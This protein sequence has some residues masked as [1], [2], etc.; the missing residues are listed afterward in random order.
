[1]VHGE[2]SSVGGTT[3]D[4]PAEGAAC[5]ESGAG[6][7]G[8]GE[9]GYEGHWLRRSYPLPGL[10][11]LLARVL[12]PEATVDGQHRVLL[13]E[14]ASL[15]T[16]GTDGAPVTEH[17]L[18][19]M[20]VA[21]LIAAWSRQAASAHA[22]MLRWIT[23]LRGRPDMNR[24]IPAV[25][26]LDATAAELQTC[27]GISRRKARGLVE[28]ARLVNGQLWPVGEALQSGAIDA[29]KSAVFADV[30]GDQ[31]IEASI[32][33]VEQVLPEASD[34]EHTALRR[35][36]QSVLVQADP[37]GVAER[38]RAAVSRRRVN[39][40][41]NRGDGMASF[42]AYLP[43]VDAAALDRA[44]ESAARAARA[45]GDAR[46]LDQLRADA[47]STMAIQ[48]L[49][50]GMIGREGET[51]DV[52]RF[53]QDR[54]KVRL[55]ATEQAQR[56]ERPVCAA[57]GLRWV[58]SNPA[59]ALADEPSPYD[60]LPIPTSCIPGLDVPYLDGYGAL[61]PAQ[62]PTL[63]GHRWITVDAPVDLGEEPPPAPGYRPTAELDRFVRR[64]DRVCQAPGCS[65]SA[66]SCDLDH[67]IAYP[68]GKTSASNL[69]AL[70]R[71]H[72]RLK[73]VGGH[74][75]RVDPEATLTWRTAGGQVLRY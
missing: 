69:R 23:V 34:L 16:E 17:V 41:Q 7:S 3:G 59:G 4:L 18:N 49:L 5:R 20:D 36:L 27:L 58:L 60:D 46:T 2:D 67:V 35:Q 39:R 33:V 32:T 25:T 50:T 22:E 31:S 53:D 26:S 9:D 73:T 21:E 28:E 64:R 66:W 19:T 62:V 29:G 43:A 70:C 44:C 54:A 56:G 1:M 74:E 75:Y 37:D 72:H 8:A 38:A 10:G 57:D 42:S 68:V 48:S 71:H 51:E 40:I 12:D 13:D 14:V 55:T 47:L 24:H 52:F 45:S 61:P 6:E 65:V 30:L 15:V 11:D 63:L